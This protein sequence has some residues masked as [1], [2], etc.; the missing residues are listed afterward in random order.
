MLFIQ[1]QLRHK[2]VLAL[3][4]GLTFA[5]FSSNA[6]AAATPG[7]E[8]DNPTDATI[9]KC[10]KSNPI[11]K[12]INKIV[13]FLSAGVGVIVISVIIVGG[14]QYSMAGDNPTAVSAAKKRIINGLI[15][16]AAFLFT[17]A[18]LNW[19]VPGGIFF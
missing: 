5:V 10:L 4:I 3:L 18:I 12:D 14:I 19:L 1:K 11:V 7:C 2:F 13:G 17:F 9:N 6:L 8:T 15:A 16:F